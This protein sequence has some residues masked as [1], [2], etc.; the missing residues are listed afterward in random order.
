MRWTIGKTRMLNKSESGIWIKR[1]ANLLDRTEDSRLEWCSGSKIVVKTKAQK[2]GNVVAM[3][4][5][6]I[7]A[8][9][10]S[11]R[12]GDLVD[13]KERTWEGIVVYLDGKKRDAKL[14]GPSVS[15]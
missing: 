6:K 1:K 4:W 8:H 2:Q 10:R 15:V 9:K 11:G 14:T 5:V 7:A 13:S 12:T 3:L